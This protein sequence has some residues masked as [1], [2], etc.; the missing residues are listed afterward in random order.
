MAIEFDKRQLRSYEIKMKKKKHIKIIMTALVIMVAIIIAVIALKFM[1]QKNY[2]N[3][4]VIN[5]MKREDSTS[6]KYLS[7]QGGVLRYSRDG[8]MAMD[9]GGNMLWNGTYQMK[10]PIV[11]ISSKFAAIADRGYK[12]VE[13]FDGE[14]GMNTVEVL[15]PIIDVNIANQGVIAVLMEG[16]ETNYIYLYDKEGVELVD[17]RTVA[18][19]DGFPIDIALSEDGR[20]LATSYVAINSGE[21]QSKLTFYNFGKVGENYEDKTTGAFDYGKTIIA[22]LEF[23]DNDTICAFGDNKF[24]IY[25]MKEI[26][27]LVFEETVNAEIKS[28]L[29][30]N[31]Y[32]GYVHENPE[33][34]LQSK[35]ML[36]DLKGN[37]VLDKN[38]DFSYENIYLS[39][40]HIIMHT[41][42]EW[43]IWE[44][45]GDEILRYTFDKN[46]NYI[47]PCTSERKFII[48]SNQ[49]MQE[50]QLVE[51]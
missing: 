25:S 12:T 3:Y 43:L 40:N 16:K 47:L 23:L 31:Q 5:T 27:K 4:Q 48:I 20:K 17:N 42:L 34:E 33:S 35:I 2:S 44:T 37:K 6:A 18:S 28:I 50:I 21:V 7:Y 49:N 30:N 38:M 19:K 10:D 11:D 1:L 9:A 15:Y 51:E 22:N 8:A 32:V 24:S 29:Y 46:I 45:D 13:I 39:G 36:Y 26:P 14:G 41:N